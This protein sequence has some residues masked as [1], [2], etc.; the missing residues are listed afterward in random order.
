MKLADHWLIVACLL[1]L[2]AIIY[3]LIDH[4]ERRA[5]C[6]KAGGM[7]F[8]REHTCVVGKKVTV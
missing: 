7:Y 8:Y 3:S 6:E 2:G 5:A 1:A 4:A